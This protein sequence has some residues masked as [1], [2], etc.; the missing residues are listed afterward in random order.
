MKKTIITSLT[1]L[2][3]GVGTMVFGQAHKPALDASKKLGEAKKSEIFEAEFVGERHPISADLDWAPILTH[4]VKKV[5]HA[6]PFQ[7]EIDAIKAEKT[8][9]KKENYLVGDN[10][11]KDVLNPSTPIVTSEFNGNPNN[12]SSPMDNGIA[13]S[14]GGIIVSVA[15][16]TIQYKNEAG[17]LLFTSGLSSF[18]GDPGIVNTCD[19]LIHYDPVADRF[20]FFA[21]ECSGNSSNSYLL[22]MFSQTNDPRDGWNYYKITGNPLSD[23]SWFDYPKLGI[24]ENELFISGNLFFNGGGFN[25][26]VVYQMEKN[27]GYTGASLTWQYWSG[28]SGSPFTLLP[29]SSGSHLNYGPGIYMVATSPFGSNTVKLYDITDDIVNSP[30][31]NYYSV[32]TTPYS[33]AGDAFQAGTSCN[34]QMGDCRSLSGFYLNGIIHFVFHSEAAG[35]W[36]AI[37]YNRLKL[38][39]LSNTSNMFDQ[40]GTN[41]LA[42]PSVSWFGLSP[43]DKS[44]II[45]YGST[46][47]SIHPQIK[48]VHCNDAGEF[49]EPTLVKESDGYASFTSTTRERWGDYTGTAKKHGVNPPVVWMNGMYGTT[50]HRWNTWIAKIEGEYFSGLVEEDEQKENSTSIAP[51]PI[52]ETF[53]LKFNIAETTPVEINIVGINGTKVKQLYTGTAYEGLNEFSFNKSNL[54]S[55]TYFIQVNTSTNQ[56]VNEK[57]IIN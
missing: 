3:C 35:G 33:V 39:G 23:G 1:L 46:N 57:V 51:N 29:V 16:T 14:N 55:G 19:P 43:D 38:D 30:S 13:I 26:S 6:F 10:A 22:I 48:A 47:N 24:S 37:N 34:L 45:G 52:L 27:D 31:L 54:A 53:I 8:A 5:D 11:D 50:T 17:T 40:A 4:K 21:Q 20:I 18:I 41:D 7:E 42:Y 15:N 9:Y 32:A 49:S 12:G 36:N 25:E 44:V 2:F 56:L 28:I